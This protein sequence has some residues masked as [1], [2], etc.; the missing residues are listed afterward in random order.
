MKKF[1]KTTD[2]SEMTLLSFQWLGET[3]HVVYWVDPLDGFTVKSQRV[4]DAV[5]F[6][7]RFMITDNGIL[8]S[9]TY[10]KV[11][12]LF[13]SSTGYYTHGTKVNGKLVLLRIHRLVADAFITNTDNKPFVNHIDGNKTN[14]CDW[15]LEWVTGQE[16]VIHAIKT[17]LLING[18]GAESNSSKVTEEM[19]RDINARKGLE[20]ARRVAA[21]HGLHHDTVCRI[22]KNNHYRSL[23]TA[24]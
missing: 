19:A 6:E 2:G 9:K 12:S 21:S 1:L 4:K 13:L 15:N 16:N 10:E 18:R 11:L 17:G 23:I 24:E 3:R 14:N 22:W 20:S 5:G 7:D 8:I